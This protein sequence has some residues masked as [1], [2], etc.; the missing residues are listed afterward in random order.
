MN[1]K[2]SLNKLEEFLS[3]SLFDENIILSKN[4]LWPK[5]SIVTPS[6]NQARYLEKTILSI[7]NQNYPNL[8]YIIIDGGSTDCS[9]E[10]ILKYKKY[11]DYWVSEKD[12]GQ[13][14]AIN[15][16]FDKSTGEILAWLN[17]D[18]IYLPNTFATISNFLKDHLNVDVLYGDTYV[19]DTNDQIVQEFKE[20]KFSKGALVHG[21][22]NLIQPNLFWRR[23]IFY[24]SGKIRTVFNFSMDID[25]WLRMFKCNAN[26]HHIPIPLACIRRHSATK[27]MSCPNSFLNESISLRKELLS[28]TYGNFRSHIFFYLYQARR[29]LFFILQG[30]LKYVVSGLAKRLKAK[31]LHS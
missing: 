8:E 19:I 24:R 28:Q 1:C 13:S 7:L 22:I 3:K 14:D 15:K 27:S 21:A 20:I 5:I 25:L 16:G 11:I 18:D 30:D 26:F 17:S 29:L 4:P 9:V 23:D 2:Y 6:F 10:I 31:L 12:N